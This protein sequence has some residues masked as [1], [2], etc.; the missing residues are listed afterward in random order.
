MI[1]V[2]KQSQS[3]IFG[4]RA[5][6]TFSSHIRRVHMHVPFTKC[7]YNIH[8]Y[9]LFV[10]LLYKVV[11]AKK[12]QENKYH[13]QKWWFINTAFRA[14]KSTLLES[15]RSRYLHHVWM[16]RICS[17]PWRILVP[18]LSGIHRVRDIYVDWMVGVFW[19]QHKVQLNDMCRI[20][21]PWAM[22]EHTMCGCSLVFALPTWS[23]YFSPPSCSA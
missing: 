13:S 9:H 17:T 8:H 16:L 11:P 6:E 3:R 21:F 2:W 10:R 7:P 23:L 5:G 18:D 14:Q 19:V 1:I 12:W 22:N 4:R 15:I 20:L